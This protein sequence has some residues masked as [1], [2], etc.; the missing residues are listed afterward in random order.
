MQKKGNIH[1]LLPTPEKHTVD[2]PLLCCSLQYGRG[3]GGG[4]SLHRLALSGPGE[5]PGG[6][7]QEEPR[8]GPAVPSHVR[9][10]P[11][12]LRS[13]TKPPTHPRPGC[14][15][16][17]FHAKRATDC[18]TACAHKRNRVQYFST[19][20]HSGSLLRTEPF[21]LDGSRVKFWNH[22]TNLCM[23]SVR[24][25]QG[26]DDSHGGPPRH[27]VP[28]GPARHLELAAGRRAARHPGLLVSV[29]THAH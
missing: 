3:P 2:T 27:H 25:S 10:A 29:R 26:C 22:N 15:D 21:E 24:T 8:S 14:S 16:F 9:S 20:E 4:R 1:H 5:G 18:L 28:P 7:A 23:C 17:L 12:V 13:A 6:A 11:V 19:T